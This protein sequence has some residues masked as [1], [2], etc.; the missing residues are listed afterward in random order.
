MEYRSGS[1]RGSGL[2]VFGL[3][4]CGLLPIDSQAGPGRSQTPAHVGPQPVITSLTPASAVAGGQGFTLLVQ[5]QDLRLGATVRWNG[6]N[7][8]LQ[9]SAHHELIARVPAADIAVGGTAIVT[10]A[11]RFGVSAPF[12]FIVFNPQP[13]VASVSPSTF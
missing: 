1:K 6:V 3:I 10:V 9:S 12:S 4:L 7:L 8:P 11:D 13:A 5:A 2:A